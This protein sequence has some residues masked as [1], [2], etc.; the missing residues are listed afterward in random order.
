DIGMDP[1]TYSLALS[2]LA[3]V[4]CATVG[5]PVTS[6]LDTVDYYISSEDL[7]TPGSE[8]HYCETLVRLKN[9]PIHMYRPTSPPR[10]KRREDFGLSAQDHVYTC[11][12]SLFK[13]HPHF[14]EILGGILRGDPRGVLLL[15]RGRVVGWE[16]LLRQRFAATLP[17]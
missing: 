6:G 3:P 10:T 8:E 12:Q 5:H 16:Q 2:R 9:L 4:Q 15:S 13:F 11:L 17:D 1:H 14:D 7:E